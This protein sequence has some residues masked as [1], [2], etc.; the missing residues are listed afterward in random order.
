M[1]L[2]PQVTPK[3]MLGEFS[4]FVV[5]R[6]IPLMP[7]QV[8]VQGITFA[9]PTMSQVPLEQLVQMPFAGSGD[10]F[11][12]DKNL[13]G[14]LARQQGVIQ[15][16]ANVASKIREGANPNTVDIAITMGDIAIPDQVSR[17]LL[18]AFHFTRSSDVE[19]ASKAARRF[20]ISSSMLFQL[21]LPIAAAI[22]HELAADVCEN[23]LSKNRDAQGVRRSDIESA[24]DAHIRFRRF[25]AERWLYVFNPRAK[26]EDA[27]AGEDLDITT[28]MMALNRGLWNAWRDRGNRNNLQFLLWERF[29]ISKSNGRLKAAMDLIRLAY[30]MIEPKDPRDVELKAYALSE[31]ELDSFMRYMQGA[32]TF[33]GTQNHQYDDKIAVINRLLDYAIFLK[34]K[35]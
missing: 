8:T 24:E 9:H 35:S 15:G 6:D 1:A 19:S 3:F 2:T 28:Q 16:H 7:F 5:S 22:C 34:V 14:A 4:N 29:N 26:D 18:G 33:L 13:H 12:G 17:D 10:R 21:G 23:F 30:S 25:A 31:H 27:P 32:R 20:H 11:I